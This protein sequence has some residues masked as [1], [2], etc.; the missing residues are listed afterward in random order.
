MIGK[1]GWEEPTPAHAP[2]RSGKRTLPQLIARS[3]E[4][5]AAIDGADLGGLMERIGDA[6]V[7]LLGE[8][9]HGTAEFY[10]M[11][12]RITRQLIEHKGFNA[13]TVEADW[14]D[15]AAIDAHVRGASSQR[16]ADGASFSRFPTWM[17][18]NESVAEF[19][20]WLRDHNTRRGDPARYTGFYGLDIYSMYASIAAVLEYLEDIDP[21]TARVARERYGC[22]IPWSQ[23][24]AGYGR[25]AVSDRY[26]ACEGEVVAM[27]QELEQKRFE[28]P[29]WDGE[30]LFDATQNA[31]LVTSAERYYRAMYYGSPASW[32]LRD[33]HMFDTLQAVLDFRGDDSKA[34]VWAHNSH[35][36]DAR[37]TEM[38]AQG[39][40]NVGQLVREAYGDRAYLIGFGTHHGT[41]AAASSWDGP[42]EVKRVR[43]SLPGSY[44]RLCHDSRV[45][46]F[47][48][49]LRAGTGTRDEIRKSLLEPRL[50]RA[51]GVIYRPETERQSH[52]FQATLPQQFDEYIWFDDTR[53][54]VPLERTPAR[55]P[56]QTFPF[57]V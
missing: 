6:R 43:P 9:S 16:P 24:P 12:A 3:C 48:L 38:S 17:W 32:N 13:V 44:E 10:D 7:V 15:A 37:A 4:P 54:V 36:G 21:P 14:P 19:V 42:M 23:D 50:E 57:G 53:A 5:F 35:L 22:L 11:R 40:H 26:Q 45:P 33:Q 39:E 25:M 52:Y 46:R 51:I 20:A 31:R 34:V 2:L 27:L 41:V 28:D 55:A 29:G 56:A 49:P 8:A 1:D 47:M 30:R 18:A